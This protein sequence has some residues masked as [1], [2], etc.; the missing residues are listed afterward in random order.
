MD[1]ARIEQ[2]GV[3]RGCQMPPCSSS[4]PVSPNSLTRGTSFL[5][6]RLFVPGQDGL[7]PGGQN[8]SRITP[9]ALFSSLHGGT[10]CVDSP[11]PGR[12]PQ[13]L[14]S[15]SRRRG[16]N[17][18]PWPQV[19]SSPRWGPQGLCV[20]A[21]CGPHARSTTRPPA[22]S[23]GGG[24]RS[25]AARKW[26]VCR[27]RAEPLTRKIRWCTVAVNFFRVGPT[28]TSD[29]HRNELSNSGVKDAQDANH[30]RRPRCRFAC[31]RGDAASRP[32]AGPRLT[33]RRR[34]PNTSRRTRSSANGL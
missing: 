11:G 1:R 15:H 21:W 25:G 8:V 34:A 13:P 7:P 14:Q 6:K 3:E 33:R 5:D 32:G 29:A 16:A 19:W 28:N 2:A 20:R 17:R 4:S 27:N 31:G 18:Q 30:S 12:P 24:P 23:M 22:F 26:G 9:V 10:P